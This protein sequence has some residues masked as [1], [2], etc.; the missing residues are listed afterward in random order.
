MI[1]RAEFPPE[2][3]LS[4]ETVVWS[5]PYLERFTATLAPGRILLGFGQEVDVPRHW[6]RLLA[7]ILYDA[8]TL[9][10]LA[11]SIA[12]RQ[13]D[14]ELAIAALRAAGS[15]RDNAF[16]IVDLPLEARYDA[17]LLCQGY[18]GVYVHTVQ[19]WERLN[20][21]GRALL[22]APVRPLFASADGGGGPMLV[23][24]ELRDSGLCPSYFAFLQLVRHVVR[25]VPHRLLYLEHRSQ[26]LY[27]FDLV[28]R[29]DAPTVIHDDGFYDSVYHS[30]AVSNA[31]LTERK[32]RRILEE[33]FHS[34]RSNDDHF[35]GLKATPLNNRRVLEAGWFALRA[36]TENWCWS[37]PAYEGMSR[38]YADAPT[39]FEFIPPLVD[40]TLRRPGVEVDMGRVLFSTT[41]HNIRRKGIVELARAMRFLPERIRATCVVGQPEFL[42][43]GIDPARHRLDVIARLPKPALVELYHR[44]AVYVRVSRDESS[45]LSILEAMACGL[46][47]I[48]PPVVA[49]NFPI[50]EDGVTGFI[51]DPGDPPAVLADRIQ[52]ICDD[53]EL[54]ARMSAECIRRAEK[55]SLDVGI[56]RLR[57]LIER[58]AGDEVDAALSRTA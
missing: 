54:R 1:H 27:T 18:G 47:V 56:G 41:M 28:A 40:T 42:P 31:R 12:S 52:R 46:P 58:T 35:Y 14:P 26:S 53:P 15:A 48:V 37:H 30:A 43:R 49:G 55:Q 5:V 11:E 45:P 8:P 9:P 17:I 33:V 3:A 10:E 16:R 7:S 38:L 20:R 51:V 39:R 44:S 6:P 19:L 13:P 34:L 22:I 4:H 25:N 29:R 50:F 36:A 57:A 32:R 2:T 24:E 21:T 23:Y